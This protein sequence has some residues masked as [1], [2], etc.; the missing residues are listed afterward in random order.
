MNSIIVPPHIQPNLAAGVVYFFKYDR[1]V[2]VCDQYVILFCRPHDAGLSTSPAFGRREGHFPPFAR[3]LSKRW[4]KGVVIRWEKGVVIIRRAF[5]RE[6]ALTISAGMALLLLVFVVLGLTK[7]LGEAALG[8]YP[9]DIVFTILGLELIRRMETLIPLATYVGLLMT[10]SRWYR[11]S[12]MTVL[13]ACGV[14]LI[15]I[16]R[17][18][19]QLALFIALLV[20][21]FSFY[22][23]PITM[24]MAVQTKAESLGRSDISIVVP[25]VFTDLRGSGRVLYVQKVR[26]DGVL[27]KIFVNDKQ[28][29]KQNVLVAQTG[30]QRIEP[31]TG[32]RLL[33][34]DHGAAYEG[35]PGEPDYRVVEFERYTLRLEPPGVVPPTHDINARPTRALLQSDDTE[36]RIEL[37]W[38]LAK[39][40]SVLILA[41]FAVVLAYTDA[42]RGRVVN[43]VAAILVYFTYNNLIGIGDTFLRNGRV[44][45]A[46]GLWWVHLTLAAT[47]AYLIAR[48]LQNRPLLPLWFG[49]RA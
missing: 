4:K 44:P 25:G 19:G 47:A 28:A 26:P 32:E 7:F 39:P 10:L 22:L 41:A 34:L 11:D 48:R 12:E 37:Q 49:G 24:G 40:I 13:A 27:E 23:S 46:V 8:Q 9:R 15:S 6:A 21:G 20:A 3:F 14:G 45:L 38:R 35:T 42:R 5:Y 36:D 31:S 16:L 1:G 17:P 2:V 30:R 29:D 33:V 43:L 18:V